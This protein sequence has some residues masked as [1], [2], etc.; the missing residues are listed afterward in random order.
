MA[1]GRSRLRR[2][3]GLAQNRDHQRAWIVRGLTLG[4]KRMNP[5]LSVIG[6]AQDGGTTFVHLDDRVVTSLVVVRG[7]FQRDDLERVWA[8]AREVSPKP[9]GG[10]FVD[11]G[12]NVGTT[13]LYAMRTGDFASAVA[14]E[15]SPDNLNVL[16]MNVVANDLADRVHVVEAACGAEAGSVG[17]WLS[18][19]AQ[20][21]HRIDRGQGA[22]ETHGTRVDVPIV[23]LDETLADLGIDPS[24]IG[25][26]WIDTQGHEPDVLAGAAKALASGA[27]FCVELWPAQYQEAGTLGSFIEAVEGAFVEFIDIHEAGGRTRP[28]RDLRAVIDRL[29]A[30]GGQ[31][32][33][34]LL[35]GR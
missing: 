9:S 14:L 18:K 27:P 7:H 35:P 25:I 22:P 12:A 6:L 30:S 15:P 17:L 3:I 20:S 19:T 33:V 5:D 34:L 16:R 24:E 31:T 28:I 8:L 11:V 23:T 26:V 4:L 21:D 1:P 2:A 10:V 13:T 32:D 29:V